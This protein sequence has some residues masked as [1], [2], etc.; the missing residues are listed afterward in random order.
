MH[1]TK[2]KILH[3]EGLHARPASKFVDTAQ[4]FQ[5]EITVSFSGERVNAKSILNVLSLGVEQGD[6]ISIRAE[7]SDSE[8]AIGALTEL[9]ESDFGDELNSEGA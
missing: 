6:E 5:S 7:G 4:E 2:L 9:I 3:P 8:A 1:E